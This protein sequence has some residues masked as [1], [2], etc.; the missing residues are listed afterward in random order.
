M[1]S[2]AKVISALIHIHIIAHD[3][4]EMHRRCHSGEIERRHRVLLPYSC[5]I[6]SS[7][8]RRHRHRCTPE[9][10]RG[11]TSFL[12]TLVSGVQRCLCCLLR[13]LLIGHEY[14]C[15][16]RWRLSIS[17]EW[18]LRCISESS[19]AIMCMC[20]S[21]DM[22]LA[23]ECTINRSKKKKNS[24]PIKRGFIFETSN[25]QNSLQ[26]LKPKQKCWG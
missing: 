17:P 24:V 23:V 4:S 7:L 5:P 25:F 14:G 19:W 21:A 6:S 26:F 9:A 3:D 10:D 15:K 1:H 18:H 20:I 13:L 16:T 2:T 22:T 12:M 8:S 11:V